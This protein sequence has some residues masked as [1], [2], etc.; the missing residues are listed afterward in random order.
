MKKDTKKQDE[1]AALR[2]KAEELHKTKYAA[3]KASFGSGATS[4]TEANI[5]KLLHELEVY[6]IELEMQNEELRRIRDIATHSAI[7]Y[8][9]LYEEIYD[10]SP[11]GY[12]TL[13]NEGIICELNLSGA[14]ILGMER[15]SIVNK[16]FSQFVA[17][18]SL[19][20]FT[21]K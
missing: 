16:N 17:K 3:K 13:S 15:S 7:E 21:H 20:V 9:N 11:S 4:P 8:A 6:Q 18:D 19:T 12:F 14:R 5:L 2:L 1:I 10:F